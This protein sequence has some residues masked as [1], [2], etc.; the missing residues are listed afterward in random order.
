MKRIDK[1]VLLDK[2]VNN[3]AHAHKLAERVL[4]QA[5]PGA[6]GKAKRITREQAIARFSMNDSSDYSFA[7]SS[8]HVDI[9]DIGL[10]FSSKV[11]G[12]NR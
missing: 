4:H 8:T 1:K 10:F 3:R 9:P 11:A 2:A 6:A 12:K 5:I 7:P